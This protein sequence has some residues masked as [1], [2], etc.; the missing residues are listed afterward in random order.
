[1]MLV[2]RR[3]LPLLRPLLLLRLLLSLLLRHQG[4]GRHRGPV[5]WS[6]NILKV[7]LIEGA[8]TVRP[9]LGVLGFHNLIRRE[10]AEANGEAAVILV[11]DAQT[12]LAGRALLLKHL[13]GPLHVPASWLVHIKLGTGVRR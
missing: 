5:L 10:R 11:R 12:A 8:D 4:H 7:L 13:G 2:L 3:L 1:M 6:Q 9:V